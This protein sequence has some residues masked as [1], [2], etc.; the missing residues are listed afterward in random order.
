MLLEGV[1][2]LSWLTVK[3]CGW[4]L[5][6]GGSHNGS[7]SE[8]VEKASARYGVCI[9]SCCVDNLTTLVFPGIL[10]DRD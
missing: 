7:A 3:A 10:I 8:S 2:I 1:K 6:A 9:L 4:Y 5:H